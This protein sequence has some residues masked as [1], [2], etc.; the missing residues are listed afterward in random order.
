[1]HDV[2]VLFTRYVGEDNLKAFLKDLS[3]SPS[4]QNNR[5]F[6]EFVRRIAKAGSVNIDPEP[7]PRGELLDLLDQEKG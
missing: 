5:L 6:A 1:M 7:Q 4:A 2:V 3:T